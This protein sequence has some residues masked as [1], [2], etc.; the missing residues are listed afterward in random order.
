MKDFFTSI[1]IT[2][3]SIFTGRNFGWHFTAITLT[4]IL[5]MTGFDWL[6]FISVRNQ[7][8]NTFFYPALFGG[9]IIPILIPLFL[10]VIA[11]IGKNFRL[12]L[13]AFALAQASF[14]GWFISSAFKAFTG[15]VQPNV[16]N[17]LLDGSH[18]F[19]FGFFK[20]GIFWGW[21][22]SHTTVAFALSFALITLLPKKNI[23]ARTLVFLWAL[24]IGIGVS[25]SIHWFSDFVAGAIIGSVIGITVGKR[26]KEKLKEE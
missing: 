26:Y 18:N 9:F 4:Y 2:I 10:F 17:L 24:Y 7:T 8:L 20:H 13:Y 6:Y 22:S 19:N 14:L 5:V 3:K 15:R 16:Y 12:K 23:Y 25:L 1:P 21:P 11:F